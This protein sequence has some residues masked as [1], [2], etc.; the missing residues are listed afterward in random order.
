MNERIRNSLLAGAVSGVCVTAMLHYVLA[1]QYI[2]ALGF[3]LAI[4]F[5]YFYDS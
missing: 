4:Y 1:I 2:Y 3:L 5:V